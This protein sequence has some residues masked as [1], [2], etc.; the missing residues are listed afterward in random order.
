MKTHEIVSAVQASAG[1]DTPEHAQRAVEATLTVLGQRL[2]TEASDLAAQLPPEL[3][4]HL[5]QDGEAE[6]FDLPEFYR[7]V[8]EQEGRDCTPD[9]ARRHARAVTAALRES[10][11]AEYRHLLDQLP[12]DWGDLLHTDNVVQH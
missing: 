5:P 8:A 9:E 11:G 10:V 1:I 2:S 7:R 3:A 12:Q 6:R 4:E